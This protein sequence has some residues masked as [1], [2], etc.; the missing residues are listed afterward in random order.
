VLFTLNPVIPNHGDEDAE[1]D[2][3]LHLFAGGW[4]SLRRPTFASHD[5]EGRTNR[6]T[7][8]GRQIWESRCRAGPGLCSIYFGNAD[9]KFWAAAGGCVCPSRI[10]SKVASFPYTLWIASLSC[11]ILDPPTSAPAKAPLEFE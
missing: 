3:S 11:P 6:E 2:P 5:R 8:M 10:P 7:R 9:M 1:N 4:D